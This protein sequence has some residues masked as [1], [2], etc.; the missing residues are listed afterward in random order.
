MTMQK[1]ELID[2]I[3]REAVTEALTVI[4]NA[5]MTKGKSAGPLGD[6]LAV[7]L[8]TV[9]REALEA[10]EASDEAHAIPPFTNASRRPGEV[11]FHDG[12]G[13]AWTFTRTQGNSHIRWEVASR[14]YPS[15]L[16]FGL[17]GVCWIEASEEG[18]FELLSAY[19]AQL[20]S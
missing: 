11:V 3:T 18:P 12:Y 7:K 8:D 15:Y 5:Y 4:D 1:D 17:K 13:T 9:I 10:Q 20:T 19:Q 6:E 14:P 16:P 2:Q